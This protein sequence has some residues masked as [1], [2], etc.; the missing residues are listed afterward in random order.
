MESESSILLGAKCVVISVDYRLAPGHPYPAAVDSEDWVI[1]HELGIDLLSRSSDRRWRL[2]PHF[3]LFEG[4]VD[5]GYCQIPSD[6]IYL[7]LN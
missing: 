2:H 7:R 1:K 3:V 5:C 6:R 4:F